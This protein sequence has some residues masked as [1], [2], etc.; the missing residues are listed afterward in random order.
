VVS[1]SLPR[2]RQLTI[3][4]PALDG[5]GLFT[6]L[7]YLV[8]FA[9]GFVSFTDPDYWWH[10]R[11]GQL[12]VETSSI[13]RHDVYSFTAAGRAWLPHEW[14]SEVLIYLL[15]RWSGYAVTLGVFVAI[16]LASFAL[17]QRLLLRLGTPPVAAAG[18]VGM[19]MVISLPAWTV[20]PQVLSWALLALFVH[21]LVGRKDPPWALVPVVALWA[22]LHLGYVFGLV[23]TGLWLVARLW[24]R[25]RQRERAGLGRDVLFFA[26]CFAATFF[27]PG[28]LDAVLYPL[29]YLPFTGQTLDVQV[30]SEWRSPDFHQPMH[31][32]LLVAIAGL[33]ALA[34]AARVRDL[35]A[36]LLAAVF[37][38]LALQ[39]SRFQPMFAVA[40]LPAAG[41]ALRDLAPR[42]L[43]RLRP[44]R[45]G[46]NWGLV[47]AAALATVAVIPW[48]PQ[49]Q[50]HRQPI[51]DGQMY[52]PAAALAWVKENRPEAKIFSAYHWGGYFID[53]LYPVGRVY[54]DGRAEMYGAEVVGDY[55]IIADAKPGWHEKLDASGADL[56]VIARSS[57]LDAPLRGD[58]GWSLVLEGPVEDVFL[59]R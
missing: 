24:G 28:G 29:R 32:P 19:G 22:N 46:L 13:P 43:P 36:V 55:R 1:V 56:V 18:L 8:F 5:L 17:M 2:S 37:T 31:L 21:T 38:A 6:C 34:C 59:R 20:R 39:A 53:G 26:A 7:L 52:Y 45:P 51:T 3:T 14:L 58:D 9:A 23:V 11:T 4:L 54:I 35:F 30:I 33:V 50:V 16:T 49:A 10:R 48:L 40:W 57:R 47:A 25:L 15:V 44:V 12:I 41:L 42:Q 27:T